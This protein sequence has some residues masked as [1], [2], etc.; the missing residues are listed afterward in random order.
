MVNLIIAQNNKNKKQIFLTCNECQHQANIINVT[1][2]R[3]TYLQI[4]MIAGRP[5]QK[6]RRLDKLRP[7]MVLAPVN[8][9]RRKK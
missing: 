6:V 2:P 7:E 4:V 9:Q 8:L 5:V 1:S 3:Q